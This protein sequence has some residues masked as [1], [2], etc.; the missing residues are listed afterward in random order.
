MKAVR[1]LIA[2]AGSERLAHPDP[3]GERHGQGARGARSPRA[4]HPGGRP[5]VAV[6][7]AAIPESLIES[8]LF[9]A[10][11]GRLHQR[12][13]QTTAREGGGSTS[14][15]LSSTRSPTCR[16][17]DAGQGPA[18]R[19]RRCASS[20]SAASESISVDVRVIAATNK[21]IQAEIKAG[22]F[23]RGPVLPHQRGARSRCRRCA[24]GID[25]MPEP[26]LPTSWRSSSGHRR[27]SPGRVSARG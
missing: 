23:R 27:R 8:E 13:W 10:R 12:R 20:A 5:F 7:C 6:N 16:L 17:D 18:G 26:W 15:T 3:R 11:E 24:S 25:D 2:Q 14:G 4:E 21:D 22:R 1:V 9:G 19:C